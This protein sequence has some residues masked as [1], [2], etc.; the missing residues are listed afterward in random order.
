MKRERAPPGEHYKGVNQMKED[1]YSRPLTVQEQRFAEENHYVIKKYLNIRKLPYNEWY[2]VV[3]FR[4]LL[5]V[6]RWF[7][8]PE[9]R[10]NNFEIVAFYAMRSAIGNELQK[11]QRRIQTVSL[12]EIIPGTEGLEYVETVTYDNLQYFYGGTAV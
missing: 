9:L 10:K 3:V 8:I 5:S 4:Y 6:K 2:D 7:S 12:N 1:I 11:Q